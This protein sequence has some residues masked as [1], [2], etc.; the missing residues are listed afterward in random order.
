MADHC[1]A[2]LRSGV[3][4]DESGQMPP[5]YLLELG[6]ILQL[7][8]WESIGLRELLK[9]ELPSAESALA[10]FCRRVSRAPESFWKAEDS[11]LSNTVLD[12]YLASVS[13]DAPELLN[14]EFII[15]AADEDRLID[16]LARLLW[17]HRHALGVARKDKPT[18]NEN[19]KG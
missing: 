1:I 6:A 19:E 18:G 3:V 5:A 17:K 15:N 4:R 2:A 9:V 12:A 13:W 11:A 16:A 8:Y 14:A 10:D 7:K